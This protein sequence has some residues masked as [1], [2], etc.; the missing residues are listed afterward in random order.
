MQYSSMAKTPLRQDLLEEITSR[1]LDGR[2]AAGTRVNEVHLARELGVSRTPLREA[3][4]GLADRG[5]LVSAPGRGFLVPPFDPDEARRLYPLV[6]ELEALALRWTSPLDLIGLPDALDVVADE[7]AAVLAGG[8]D[9]S[10]VDDR[11]HALLLSRCGNPHLLR[12]IDQTKPLLKRYESCYFGGVDRAG[13]SIGEH[14]RIAAALREGDLP[15]ASSVLVRN[16]VK[17]L[18]YLGKD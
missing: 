4:I 7:M 9:V 13:E 1:V 15:T 12:L 5:L 8:G 2:L 17:A 11:W 16:W 10:P 18:A 6:A 14:R 3:L